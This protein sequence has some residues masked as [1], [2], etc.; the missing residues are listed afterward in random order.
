MDA[1]TKKKWSNIEIDNEAIKASLS[2]EP[3]FVKM[4]EDKMACDRINLKKGGL[5]ELSLGESIPRETTEVFSQAQND[6]MLAWMKEPSNITPAP[7]TGD[8][9]EG[10]VT[11][12]GKTLPSDEAKGPVRGRYNTA[13]AQGIWDNDS[14]TPETIS[15]AVTV[16]ITNAITTVLKSPELTNLLE[17]MAKTKAVGGMMEALVQHGGRQG[18]DARTMNQNAIEMCHFAEMAFE[19]YRKTLKSK[20]E[21]V[22]DELVDAERDFRESEKETS[23]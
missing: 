8:L 21:G 11:Y 13:L 22:S 9:F 1:E 12:F 14:L 10:V 20:N 15:T 4:V 18:L 3:N 16:G 19:Q 7:P 2:D 17:G 5:T 23:S 6:A